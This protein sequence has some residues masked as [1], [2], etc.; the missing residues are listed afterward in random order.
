MEVILLEHVAKLGNVGQLV[1]VKS[2]YGRNFL[3]PTGKAIRATKASVAEFEA[4]RDALE[5]QNAKKR[6]EAKARASTIGTLSVKVVR[7]ASDDGKLFGSVAVR[8][9]AL[10]LK[11]QLGHEFDRQQ[12]NLHSSIKNLG[13]YHASIM[14]H[15]EVKITCDVQVVRNME[16]T[17]YDDKVDTVE[18]AEQEDAA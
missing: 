15:P 6:D 18:T 8:D 11:D 10:A 3:I 16:A 7:Q 4:Q 9:V 13:L 1:S 12:I 5:Q 2:G 14:L 17:A